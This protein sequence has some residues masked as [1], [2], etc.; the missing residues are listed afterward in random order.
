[1]NEL[2]TLGL[3]LLRVLVIAAALLAMLF[4]GVGDFV[5]RVIFGR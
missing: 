5:R 1:M 3:D 4:L 2:H